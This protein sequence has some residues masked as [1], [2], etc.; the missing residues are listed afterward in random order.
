MI[1]VR[2][3]ECELPPI[4]IDD[5]KTLDTRQHVD[6]FPANTWDTNLKSL[7]MAIKAAV[8]G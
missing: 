7:L 3:S 5:V 6:L 4:E 2:L 1:P 8:S